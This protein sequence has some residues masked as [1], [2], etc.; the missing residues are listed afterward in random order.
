[1]RL[2]KLN[3][4]K[5]YTVQAEKSLDDKTAYGPGIG[6]SM[7]VAEAEKEKDMLTL[8]FVTTAV[9]KDIGP[10]I[11]RSRCELRRGRAQW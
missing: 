7:K 2:G 4:I 3:L 10:E 8:M 6:G 1:M 9:K 11:T 5:A